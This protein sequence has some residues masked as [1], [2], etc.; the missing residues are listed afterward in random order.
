M[1]VVCVCS[2]WTHLRWKFMVLVVL[3]WGGGGTFWTGP[4]GVISRECHVWLLLSYC[5]SFQ[6]CSVYVMCKFNYF[7]GSACWWLGTVCCAHL[8]TQFGIRIFTGSSLFVGFNTGFIIICHQAGNIVLSSIQIYIS[9][10]VSSHFLSYP[11][12]FMPWNH[13]VQSCVTL[14]TGWVVSG[15][16]VFFVC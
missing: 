10:L 6:T 4:T 5:V 3:C 8:Q 13:H 12:V 7:T 11:L 16:I 9:L 15:L 1:C 14:N 2:T